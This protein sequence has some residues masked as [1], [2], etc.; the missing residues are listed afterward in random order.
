MVCMDCKY[1]K[2][3]DDSELYICTN[4]NSEYFMKYAIVCCEDGCE[5]GEELILNANPSN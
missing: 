2:R 3:E 5:D 1:M 4:R